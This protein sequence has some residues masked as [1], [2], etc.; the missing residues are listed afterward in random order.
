MVHSVS[1]MCSEG[2]NVEVHKTVKK[3]IVFISLKNGGFGS[4]RKSRSA[5]PINYLFAINEEK[6]IPKA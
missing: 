4:T 6:N 3:K 1:F 5:S 2:H